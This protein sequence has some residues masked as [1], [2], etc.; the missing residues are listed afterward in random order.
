MCLLQH[1]PAAAAAPPALRLGRGVSCRDNATR[2]GQHPGQHPAAPSA[3]REPLRASWAWCG[4]AP[5]TRAV[6]KHQVRPPPSSSSCARAFPFVEVSQGTLAPSLAMPTPCPG[7]WQPWHQV[8]RHFCFRGDSSPG[9]QLLR[10]AE[11]GAPTRAGSPS[12]GCS[13]HSATFPGRCPQPPAFAGPTVAV[14]CFPPGLWLPPP[15]FPPPPFPAR[16]EVQAEG[17]P[18]R[19][20]GAGARAALA[21]RARPSPAS[22]AIGIQFIRTGEPW[23][24]GAGS[25]LGRG[26]A[27]GVLTLRVPR[28]VVVPAVWGGRWVLW[29]CGSLLGMLGALSHVR[30]MLGADPRGPRWLPPTGAAEGG[31]DW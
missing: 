18:R 11:P 6:R 26:D 29:G 1:L 14:T 9:A 4:E 23:W 31:G 21:P 27:V 13:P 17:G 10:G 12:L 3:P 5:G 16:P 2:P 28:S 7:G 8:C 22:P 25:G 24:E 20:A 30:V 19:P 15:L